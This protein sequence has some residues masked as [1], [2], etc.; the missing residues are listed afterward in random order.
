LSDDIAIELSLATPRRRVTSLTTQALFDY[1][2]VDGTV[3]FKENY[4]ILRLGCTIRSHL[5]KGNA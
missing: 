2:M 1:E 5:E 3:K 4:R